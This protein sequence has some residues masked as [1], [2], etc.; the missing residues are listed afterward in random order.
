MP[1]FEYRCED[2]GHCFEKLR[3]AGDEEQEKTTCPSC[4]G[5]RTA[6]QMSCASFIGGATG[7]LCAP[8]GSGFS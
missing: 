1:I 4:G 2:C 7:G 3:M 6:K 8:G 5:T